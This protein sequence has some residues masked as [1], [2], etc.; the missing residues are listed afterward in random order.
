[1][2]SSASKNAI[3]I[4]GNQQYEVGR[5]LGKG[6]FGN[7]R[8]VV[9]KDDES[10]PIYAIKEVLKEEVI[11]GHTYASMVDECSLLGLVQEWPFVVKIYEAFQTEYL[12]CIRMAFLSGGELRFHL[13]E[14]MEYS[15]FP[16]EAILFYGGI[17]MQTLGYMHGRGVV[18]RDIKLE[19]ILLDAEGYCYITDFNVATRLKEGE[20][21]NSSVGT[22]CYMAPE[23]LSMSSSA[24]ATA[25]WW[26]LG[27]VLY[28]LATGRR[29]FNY[30]GDGIRD[31]SDQ[32]ANIRSS[33]KLR[34][35]GVSD[36][37]KDVILNLLCLDPEERFTFEKTSKHPFFASFMEDWDKIKSKQ[38]EAPI[39]PNKHTINFDP[40]VEM[41]DFLVTSGKKKRPL[42]LKEQERFVDWDW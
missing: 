2:G 5:C 10:K 7:V 22:M 8:A 26:S 14:T 21:F 9:P 1:M 42:T 41:E 11:S 35:K 20:T 33:P 36:D 27:C 40:G 23:V 12:L 17:L 18:H 34:F 6:S 30:S 38:I 15:S 37:L 31:F 32:L 4:D 39:Q 19:N 29:P 16:E 25:D 24:N 3:I 13:L 28:E